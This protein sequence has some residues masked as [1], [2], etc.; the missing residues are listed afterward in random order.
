MF[1]WSIRIYTAHYIG[2]IKEQ[3]PTKGDREYRLDR[4]RH[5]Y[6]TMFRT[7]PGNPHRVRRMV[8]AEM[9]SEF[10]KRTLSNNADSAREFQK[11]IGAGWAGVI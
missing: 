8:L 5:T 3:L 1:V 4:K 9:T 2:G 6:Q 7:N 11:I 10:L